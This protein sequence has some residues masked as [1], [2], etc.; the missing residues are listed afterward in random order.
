[1]DEKLNVKDIDLR[2]LDDTLFEKDDSA[3]ADADKLNRPSVTYWSDAWRRFRGNK[4]AMVSA[5]ILVLV[6]FMA[7]F[8]PM[9]SPYTY[10][11]QDLFAINQ[12]PSSEHWFG[13]DE[14]GRDIF[15]R[16]W[17]GAR[18]SLLIAFVVAVLNGTIGIL[19]GGIAGYFGGLA[20]NVMMRFCELI[21]SIPQML[22]VV[23]LILIMRPGIFP[24]IIAIA[25]TGWI[26]TARL[27][28]GQVFSLKESE[29]VMASRTM[30][31]GSIWIIL[32]H[33]LPNAMSP[34]I[35][36][37]ANV[38]P[39]AIF[40]EAFLSYIGLGVPLPTAS[41]GILASDGANKLLSYPYQL[42][43]P[44]LLICIT[45][46]CFNLMGDGL[47]DALDPRMRQ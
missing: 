1:M 15:V 13:T 35:I 8:Q 43:F 12:G 2:N 46:L 47:R 37:M 24:I 26:G 20:D 42:F 14:L 40:S 4:V 30:G 9:A 41:W 3:Y 29:F 34:I 33:L 38:I 32:K 39:G 18:V 23:L 27:F 45:M 31:A 5:V 17:E 36:S 19:Y 16:C 21:A 10:D 22:W 28:R 11:E 7:V 25:A 44:S 6:I